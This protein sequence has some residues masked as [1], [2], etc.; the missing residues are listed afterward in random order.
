[1][2]LAYLTQP[3]LETSTPNRRDSSSSRNLHPLLVEVLT[4]TAKSSRQGANPSS[5]SESSRA[6]ADARHCPHNN[7]VAAFAEKLTLPRQCRAT[8][9]PTVLAPS[10][11]NF[12]R[13]R[14]RPP[15]FRTHSARERAC[16]TISTNTFR[17]SA[18]LLTSLK[19]A[20]RAPR[21]PSGV[22]NR[23]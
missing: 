16:C 13:F 20:M 21:M 12:Q 3:L 5:T 14:G 4:A 7:T 15:R 6:V 17:V 9:Y 10:T 11:G 19:N 23:T 22:F 1:M 18:A 2:T 8:D